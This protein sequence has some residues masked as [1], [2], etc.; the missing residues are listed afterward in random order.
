[1]AIR[2]S[3]LILTN[4]NF[5]STIALSTLSA[6]RVISLPNATGEVILNTASQTLSN[7]TLTAPKIVADGFIADASGVA[8]LIFR[9]DEI[10]TPKKIDIIIADGTNTEGFRI[11]QNDI[12]NNPRGQTIVSA[13]N[14]Y[15]LKIDHN[16]LGDRDTVNIANSSTGASTS[17]GVG[18]YN[19]SLSVFKVTNHAGQQSGSIFAGLGL[20]RQ[21]DPGAGI[22]FRQRVSTIYSAL[23]E[24]IGEA[25]KS[26]MEGNGTSFQAL[27]LATSAPQLDLQVANTSGNI[28][29]VTS[30]AN[31]ASGSFMTLSNTNASSAAKA[32]VIEHAGTGSYL[33]CTKSGVLQFG[34]SSSGGLRSKRYMVT[35]STNSTLSLGE[36]G[37]LCRN[38]GATSLT[39]LTLPAG[40]TGLRYGFLVYDADGYRIVG[41]GSER[42]RIAG[43]QSTATTGY[44]ES[45]TVGNV[46]WLVWSGIEWVAET[47]I[48][49]TPW[50]I[51]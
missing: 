12:T 40:A 38:N 2:T 30:S 16:S 14:N 5:K 23:Q 26:T 51:V 21:A 29:S 11:T 46:L 25:Y 24:G 19:E 20:N 47:V 35:K 32:I 50:T 8:Q 9:A 18:A 42:I 3:S 1:M 49:S 6:N 10:E 36:T 48:V 28:I 45:L 15:A 31:H 43:T 4:G 7:K 41:N 27:S 17:V 44:V 13:S 33:E 34:V 22:T 39:T 37:A